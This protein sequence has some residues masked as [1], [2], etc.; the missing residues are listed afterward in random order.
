[1]ALGLFKKVE[2][3]GLLITDIKQQKY[4]KSFEDFTKVKRDSDIPSAQFT[5]TLVKAN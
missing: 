2:F 5:V 3:E 1:M 4:T